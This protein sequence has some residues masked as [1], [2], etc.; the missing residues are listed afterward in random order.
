[1]IRRSGNLEAL[2]FEC[3]SEDYARQLYRNFHEVS[4]RSKL[5]RHRRRKSDGGSI[6]TRSTDYLS[7]I[8]GGGKSDYR[9]SIAVTGNN[10]NNN[11]LGSQIGDS[12]KGSGKGGDSASSILAGN[13][14]SSGR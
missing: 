8:G 11:D 10:I 7:G 3:V 4:K 5:E 1:M 13:N 6:V 9:G 2:V 14:G 12:S